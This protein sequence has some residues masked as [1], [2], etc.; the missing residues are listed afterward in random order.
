MKTFIGI[1]AIV[2]AVVGLG[3]YLFQQSNK[4]VDP[5]SQPGQ[6]YD[7]LGAKHIPEG[8][9][10][11]PAYNSNPPSSGDHWPAAAPWGV[12]DSEQ[13]DEWFIH[14]LEHGG[15]WISYKPSTVPAETQALLKEFAKRYRKVI[16]SPRE[17]NDANIALAAWR[18]VQKLETFDEN[19]ILKFIESYYDQGPEKV[20]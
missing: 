6:L 1:F 15:I 10:D 7:D 16:V 18:R 13:A 8:T 2:L 14:N 5:A 17:A 3:Y 20:P 12:Y 19:T 9:K 11:H 4:P